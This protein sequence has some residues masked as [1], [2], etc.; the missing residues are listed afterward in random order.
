MVAMSFK[1]LIIE[2]TAMH[3]PGLFLSMDCIKRKGSIMNSYTDSD[4]I[5]QNWDQE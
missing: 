5:N 2:I 3:D 1:N 4:D